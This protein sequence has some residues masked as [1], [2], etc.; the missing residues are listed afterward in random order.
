VFL[1]GR[2]ATLRHGPDRLCPDWPH[3]LGAAAQAPVR[4][5][6]AAL[7]E[8][9]RR[10]TEDLRDHPPTSSRWRFSPP[11]ALEA[12]VRRHGDA[13]RRHG[14]RSGSQVPFPGSRTPL[15]K[16]CRLA[17]QIEVSPAPAGDGPPVVAPVAQRARL[18]ADLCLPQETTQLRE[19]GLPQFQRLAPLADDGAEV[20]KVHHLTLR[21]V[22]GRWRW[23]P[24]WAS[25][26]TRRHRR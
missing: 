1:S 26:S 11:F 17:G 25:L 20:G 16:P 6:H 18:Q 24:Q 2:V 10:G 13:R 19:P 9:P 23:P 4:Y 3:L 15:A 22:S 21:P 14:T 7:P 12:A 8:L 5:R